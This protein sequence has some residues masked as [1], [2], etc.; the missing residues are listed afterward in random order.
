MNQNSDFIPF[1]LPSIGQE[2]KKAV[3]DVLDSGWLT[4]GNKALEFEKRF[5]E[6]TEAKHAITVNSATSGLHLVLE[7]FGICR[8]SRVLTTPYTFASTAEVIRYMDAH[9]V[10]ADINEDDYNISPEYAEKALKN[11]PGIRAVIPVHIGGY[12]CD[13]DRIKKSAEKYSVKVIE[14]AAHAFPVKYKG[15][16]AGNLSDAGVFSFYATKTITTG[17]GGMVVTNSDEAAKRMKTMRLHGIDRDVWDRY[18]SNKKKWF[19]EV[20]EPGFKYNMTDIAAAMG[21]E[22]LKKAFVFLE[23]RKKT[24]EMYNKAFSGYDFIKLPPFSENHAWHLYTIR[25]NED[26]LKITRDE[27]INKMFEK[28]IGVSVHFIPLHI[29]PYYKRKYGLKPDDFPNA[30]KKYQQTVSLP[31]YPDLTEEQVNR[32]INAVIQT[33]KDCSR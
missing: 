33:G 2:E 8:D 29:M 24:A 23:K 25:I 14:D 7:S 32:V 9:P 15:S 21:I 30:L 5:A 3:M 10:F 17:E 22:Q 18:N 4:T 28:G 26:K 31:I 19:Y 27:F 13:M 6:I 11:N 12:I 1:A 16:S 20:V